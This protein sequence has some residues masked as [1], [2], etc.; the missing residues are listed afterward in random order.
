VPF[1]RHE[2]ILR[3]EEILHLVNIAVGLGIFKVRVTGGE[4]LVRKGVYTF[5][6][7]LAQVEGLKDISLT[8][9]GVLLAKNIDKIKT[10]GISRINISLDTLR[11]DRFEQITGKKR[12]ATVWEGI[13]AAHQLG[14]SPIKINVVTLRGINDDELVE[15]ARLSLFYPFH[16]RFIEYM[17]M[18]ADEPHQ[19]R[20][21][22]TAVLKEQLAAQNPLIPIARE[23]NDGPAERFKFDGALGEIGFISAMSHHFCHE[24]NRLRLTASGHLRPCLL[25]NY[26]EDLKTPLRAGASDERLAKVFLNA[27]KNKPLKHHLKAGQADNIAAQMSAIGG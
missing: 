17:P 26:Q 22:P 12:F 16:I 24:C 9:N 21:I 11:P 4:P 7:R 27:I 10:A 8:T 23:A 3:Y 14:F 6:K 13:M 2:D 19:C 5:L 18:G 15:I 1:L 25:S 20:F